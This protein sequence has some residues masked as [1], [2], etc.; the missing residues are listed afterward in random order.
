MGG[1]GG[2]KR[3][4]KFSRKKRKPEKGDYLTTNFEREKINQEKRP[5]RKGEVK[6][7]FNSDSKKETQNSRGSGRR[8]GGGGTERQL[9]IDL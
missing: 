4:K 7:H 2:Q 9:G 5:I 3:G 8:G 6:H 1:P